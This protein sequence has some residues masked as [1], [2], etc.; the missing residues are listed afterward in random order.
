LLHLI[1]FLKV[2]FQITRQGVKSQEIKKLREEKK[3]VEEIINEKFSESNPLIK[4]SGSKAKGTMI[5]SS[6]DLDVAIY[7]DHDDTSWG[8]T[9]KDIFNSVKDALSDEYLPVPKNAAIRLESKSGNNNY[10]HIDVVPGRFISKDKEDVFLYQ[11]EGDKNRLQTNLKEHIKHISESGLR[12][13]IK[14]AKI[15]KIKNNIDVKTFILE[16]SLIKILKDKVGEPIEENMV[17]FW[18]ELRDNIDNLSIVDPAN[19]GNNL[20]NLLV[21]SKYTLSNSASTTLGYINSDSWE[22]IFG[23]IEKENS[24]SGV[25]MATASAIGGTRSFTPHSP[26]AQE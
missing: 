24:V 19:S 10:T 1:L 5:K 12:E 14:L 21:E 4:Y 8:E 20:T 6:Y 22:N 23:E 11:N 18:E 13:E 9:L 2:L 26:Y 16:L 17:L 3:K 7:F 15:W 25:K